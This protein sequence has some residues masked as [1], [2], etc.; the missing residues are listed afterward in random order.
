MSLHDVS[1]CEKRSPL[2]DNDLYLL[3]QAKF[4]T[5]LEHFAWSH[6]PDGNVVVGDELEAVDCK[7]IPEVSVD[8]KETGSQALKDADPDIALPE[9]PLATIEEACQVPLPSPLSIIHSLPPTPPMEP[10]AI[11]H[12]HP[13][14]P[15]VKGSTPRPIPLLLHPDPTPKPQE[16]KLTLPTGLPASG[17]SVSDLMAIPSP[18]LDSPGRIVRRH[19]ALPSIDTTPM[20]RLSIDLD[21]TLA[22]LGDDD[23][24]QLDTDGIGSMPNGQ[25]GSSFF[26]RLKQRPATLYT[27]GLRRQTRTSD[28]LSRSGSP[29]KMN[30]MP[31]GKGATTIKA[32]E[33]IKAF[34]KLRKPSNV[35]FDQSNPK[36]P[37]RVTANPRRHTDSNSWFDKRPKLQSKSSAVDREVCLCKDP[38]HRTPSWANDSEPAA[39]PMQK[40]EAVRSSRDLVKQV[41]TPSAPVPRVELTQTPP[42]DIGWLMYD[43]SQRKEGNV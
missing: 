42:L 7:V 25:P 28:A 2:D 10:K 3:E 18:G 34:P 26:N 29:V 14:E 11:P 8:P 33:K 1:Y 38:T 30:P 41:A 22:N 27:S 9:S 32:F 15:I 12:I 23:W 39:V 35:A 17:L 37:G 6:E 21:G 4:R 36:W 31:L 16:T 24:E 43:K 40:T 19:R 5:E 20:S 13:A